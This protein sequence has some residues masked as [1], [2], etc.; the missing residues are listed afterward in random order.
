MNGFSEKRYFV[1]FS[2]GEKRY[3]PSEVEKRK[4]ENIAKKFKEM[5]SYKAVNTGSPFSKGENDER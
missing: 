2:N 4:F 5:D 1:E 3:F